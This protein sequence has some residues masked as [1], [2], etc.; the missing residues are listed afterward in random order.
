MTPY[1]VPRKEA[2]INLTTLVNWS[3]VSRQR[4]EYIVYV[5]IHLGKCLLSISHCQIHYQTTL[6][7]LDVDFFKLVNAWFHFLF[8]VFQKEILYTPLF[9]VQLFLRFWPDAVIREGL[10]SRFC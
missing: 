9:R 5:A 10:I 1:Q 7:Y 6:Y 3:I 8:Y 4:Y 2:S